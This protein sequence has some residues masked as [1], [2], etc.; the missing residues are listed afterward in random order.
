MLKEIR[1]NKV[2]RKERKH[3]YL[4]LAKSLRS[5]SHGELAVFVQ[6]L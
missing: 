1:N 4:K 5:L 3:Q 6:C 2:K